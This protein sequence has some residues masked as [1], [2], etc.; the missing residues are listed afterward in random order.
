ML[1]TIFD[2]SQFN[3]FDWSTKEHV[4]IRFMVELLAHIYGRSP[5]QVIKVLCFCNEAMP[6]LHYDELERD[7]SNDTQWELRRYR[8]VKHTRELL[9]N[10]FES[11]KW[12]RVPNCSIDCREQINY[13]SATYPEA[14]VVE[15]ISETIDE[16]GMGEIQRI[17]KPQKTV[18]FAECWAHQR[19][20]EQYLANVPTFSS[21]LKRLPE[22]AVTH[23]ASAG[24]INQTGKRSLDERR[25]T[26]LLE[27]T[28][29]G[30][31]SGDLT[32]TSSVKQLVHYIKNNGDYPNC[33]SVSVEAIQKSIERTGGKLSDDISTFAQNLSD[34]A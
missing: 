30:Q 25:R 7:S 13:K 23:D 1:S 21:W 12:E 31:K 5:K 27:A 10:T 20:I 14:L 3:R 16:S 6:T 11:S 4:G 9:S 2:S 18:P 19:E 26:E 22:L 33:N 8:T 24:Q 34:N 28:I 29:A 32:T 17:V 15:M